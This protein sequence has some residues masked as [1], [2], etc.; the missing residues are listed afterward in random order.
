MNSQLLKVSLLITRIFCVWMMSLWAWKRIFSDDNAL[1][2]VAKYYGETLSGMGASTQ[3][4]IGVVTLLIYLLALI[5]FKKK[6]TYFF[7]FLV[8]LI[9]TLMVFKLSFPLFESYRTTWFTS[10]PALMAMWL[11]WVL[12]KED[13]L[14][15][16]KGKWS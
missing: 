4:I 1:G 9:G 10:F 3:V 14:L 13:T 7:V 12:R 8:H 5:G 11:L 6:Y 2:M 15:S 16:L